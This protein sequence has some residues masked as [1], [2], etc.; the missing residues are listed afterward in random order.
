MGNFDY[1]GDSFLLLKFTSMSLTEYNN[2]TL[3]E[4]SYYVKALL[5]FLKEYK[6][7]WLL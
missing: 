5:K 6:T 7:P 4:E 2:L 3:D 1:Y